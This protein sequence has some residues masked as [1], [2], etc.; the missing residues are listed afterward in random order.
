MALAGELMSRLGSLLP[1]QRGQ[2]QSWSDQVR[3]TDTIRQQGFWGEMT[4]VWGQ[5]DAELLR[6]L[7]DGRWFLKTLDS[8]NL[9][10]DDEHP[11]SAYRD[12]LTLDMQNALEDVTTVRLQLLSAF[13]QDDGTRVFWVERSPQQG[14]ISLGGAPLDVSGLLRDEVFDRVRTSVL[15]SATMTID[16]SFDYIVDRLGLE[17]AI[18]L[19]LGSPFDHERST[20]LYIADDMPDPNS[21][22]FQSTVTSTLIELLAATQGRA[23]VLFTSHGALQATHK[24]IKQPLERKN[25]S[26]L[27][28][29]VDGSFRQLVERLRANTGTV[30][31]GTSS[32][33]EGVDVVGPALSLVVIVKLPFP[34]P[35]DPVFEARSE[36]SPDPFNELSVPQAVLKFKQGF[37]RL[38]R[39]AS[40]RG[41]CVVLDR[42]IVTRRYG[43]SFIH[44]LPSSRVVVGSTYDLP[45]SAENWLAESNLAVR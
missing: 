38:I 29:H 37:G 34:V 5:L 22:N 41:V 40:D 19:P 21:Q 3:L 17:N 32:F 2:R 42:R 1:P 30:L 44:S 43:Q 8:L 18:R 35:S 12:E 13:G 45:L 24:A 31:L 39:S 26:V 16:G 25:I 20:L 4:L 11:E 14:I 9:P 15:T 7:D 27:G 23:L 6:V 36:L 10:D 28:Q 33:W